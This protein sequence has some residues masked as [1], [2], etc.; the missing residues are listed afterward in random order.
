MSSMS[1]LRT[2]RPSFAPTKGYAWPIHFDPTTAFSK[3][4]SAASRRGT[5]RGSVAGSVADGNSARGDSL[6]PERE[7]SQAQS[8][9]NSDPTQV[10]NSMPLLRA[11]QTTAA[12]VQRAPPPTA[13][14]NA[15]EPKKV[16]KSALEL[17]NPVIPED[18]VELGLGLGFGTGDG[19]PKTARVASLTDPS[20][21]FPLSNPI[22]SAKRVAS[23]ASQVG[24]PFPGTE[25]GTPVRKKKKKGK[26]KRSLGSM[27]SFGPC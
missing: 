18:P 19:G 12:H 27:P 14:T 25:A 24:S 6:R 3:D 11:I 17:G 1:T 8:L 5:A 7:G 26:S 4:G 22:P 23:G 10:M 2:N 15:N 13:S 16:I 9:S 21:P 20:V